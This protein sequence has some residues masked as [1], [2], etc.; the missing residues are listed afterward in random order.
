[1]TEETL[2]HAA[3]RAIRFFKIDETRGG[4]LISQNTVMAIDRLQRIVDRE[5]NAVPH[6]SVD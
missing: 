3:K 5:A 4:G 2:A 6:V 1:M